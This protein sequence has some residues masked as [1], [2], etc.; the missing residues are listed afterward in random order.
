MG[1]NS[2]TQII[3][4][5]SHLTALPRHVWVEGIFQ[6]IGHCQTCQPWFRRLKY[7]NTQIIWLA[8]LSRNQQFQCY[9]ALLRFVINPMESLWHPKKQQHG[10][11][12]HYLR[13]LVIWS[14]HNTRTHMHTR[15]HSIMA[16]CGCRLALAEAHVPACVSLL[17]IL[18]S[19]CFNSKIRN[20]VFNS[21][22]PFGP[23]LSA[24]AFP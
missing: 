17:P 8:K 15:A 14:L 19:S 13:Y 6:P 7:V 12:H 20:P 9:P 5:F 10:L 3:W 16:M 4:W 11:K 1:T 2:N 18:S 22:P 24:P 21:W 23:M